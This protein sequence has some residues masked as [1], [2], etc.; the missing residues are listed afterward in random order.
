[1][2]NN[3]KGTNEGESMSE[4]KT[5]QYINENGVGCGKPLTKGQRKFCVDC[6]VS[7]SD[8]GNSAKRCVPCQKE[9]DKE[10]RRV[11]H[12]QLNIE[13][14]KPRISRFCVGCGE[15]I[16]VPKKDTW[17]AWMGYNKKLYCSDCFKKRRVES[18]R[19]S[20]VETNSY[21]HRLFYDRFRRHPEW[22][23]VGDVS[24]VGND[25][26]SIGPSLKYPN[27]K[28]KDEFESQADGGPVKRLEDIKGITPAMAR[29]LR[30]KGY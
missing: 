30:E 14:R 12:H 28:K 20:R 3:V 9:H 22:F 2:R 21:G 25:G 13:K 4:E 10:I 1:V 24:I 29:K 6:R 26:L 7:I 8:R 27:K 5:C 19:K 23:E 17:Q 15:L 11:R 16:P 18:K